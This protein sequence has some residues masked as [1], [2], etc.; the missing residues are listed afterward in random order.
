AFSLATLLTPLQQARLLHRF[1]MPL[2]FL[3]VVCEY[4]KHHFHMFLFVVDTSL[5]CSFLI[6]ILNN[7]DPF[8]TFLVGFQIILFV[9]FF[10]FYFG[11]V[12]HLIS[13]STFI[14]GSVY[15]IFY[16]MF[17]YFLLLIFVFIF[18]IHSSLIQLH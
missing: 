13:H 17:S 6:K 3:F 16:F 9:S 1:V 7:F 14:L 12:A 8:H 11:F 5:L 10:F 2:L 4:R 18:F 15:F